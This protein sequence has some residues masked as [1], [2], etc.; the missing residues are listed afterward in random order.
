MSIWIY[1][2]QNLDLHQ[3]NLHANQKCLRVA[4]NDIQHLVKVE[5]SVFNLNL[6]W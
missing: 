5:Y 3:Q 2:L 1:P 6:D 4:N